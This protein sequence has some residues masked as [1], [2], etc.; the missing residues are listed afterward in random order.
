MDINVYEPMKREQPKKRVNW[1]PVLDKRTK[2]MYFA[3]F[4]GGLSLIWGECGYPRI[5]YINNQYTV[6]AYD[7]PFHE[8]LVKL[9]KGEFKND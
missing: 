3:L 8:M 7:M 4:F 6:C 1:N 9:V 2:A 5:S